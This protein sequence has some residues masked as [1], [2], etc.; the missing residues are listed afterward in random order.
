MKIAIQFSLIF[1]LN[2]SIGMCNEQ[3][4]IQS[5]CKITNDITNSNTDKKD[6]LI[7]NLGGKTWS[8]TINK[9]IECIDDE[10]AVVVTD[11][12]KKM[13][14]KDLRKAAVIIIAFKEPN[15]VSFFTTIIKLRH[16]V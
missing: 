6:V 9:I 15:E 1:I 4:L 14:T 10:T 12:S 2:S 11:L 16:K 8:L 5:I 7:G 3:N 13:T